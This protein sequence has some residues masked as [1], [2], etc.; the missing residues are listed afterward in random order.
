MHDIVL[1]TM[2]KS[3]AL[4]QGDWHIISIQTSVYNKPQSLKNV[5]QLCQDVSTK[6]EVIFLRNGKASSDVDVMQ[7]ASQLEMWAFM[8]MWEF[9]CKDT[10]QESQVN[11]SK[12]GQQNKPTYLA[13]AVGQRVRL[14]INK[15]LLR[16]LVLPRMPIVNDYVSAHLISRVLCVTHP[17]ILLH[18]TYFSI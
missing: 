15:N 14:Y 2:S 9:E 16:H 6:Q 5:L 7:L 12:G 11:N 3:G 8:K 10:V 1:L 13:L 18:T 17:L 4:K